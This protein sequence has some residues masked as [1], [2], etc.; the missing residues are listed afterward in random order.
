M[1]ATPK[2]LRS[3][4][5][6][7]GLWTDQSLGQ[8]LD[9]QV[10][11]SAG[12]TLRLWSEQ[13]PWQGTVGEAQDL[14][15]Q[16]AGGLREM[17]V[18]QGDVVA[19][20]LPNCP[21][22]IATFFAVTRLGA[23]LVPIVHFYGPKEV[24]YILGE[25]GAKV[26]ITADAFGWL[27]YRANLK[28]IRPDL[29]HLEEVVFVPMGEP[30]PNLGALTDATPLDELPDVD[31]DAAAL[32]AYTSGTTADPKGVIHTHRS[33]V[34]EATQLGDTQPTNGHLPMLNG[35]PLGHAIGMLGGILLPLYQ[36]NEMHLIDVW[37]PQ[38][39]LDAML[40]A[41][42]YAGSGATYF[43]L[44]LLDHPALTSE[45]LAKMRYI[46]LGGASVPLAVGERATDLGI[47]LI[48]AYGS[49]EHPST[50]GASHDEPLAKRIT[51]DGRPL[52]GVEL[53]IVDEGGNDLPRGEAG[54][55]WSRGPELCAGYTDA[56]LTAENF[57]DDGWY[58]TGDVGILDDDGWLTITDRTRDIIIRGGETIS[59]VE[60]EDLLLR[61]PEVAE[62]AVVAAPD[63]RLGEH[64]CA[65]IR[66]AP[67]QEVP[68]VA[69]VRAHLRDAGL[70]K[71]KWPE[72]IREVDD[73]PRT[74]SGKVKRFELRDRLRETD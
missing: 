33:I 47:S 60:V 61:M 69:A 57:T 49:T 38:R 42:I 31:P 55:I 58:R 65:F 8:Y 62:V 41:N 7:E 52:L 17:G 50:T 24:R 39:I 46:G 34:A 29:P 68:D 51:T 43:L 16:I 53:R 32:I 67:D 14:G 25:S 3:R 64:G 72:E 54:E 6:T 13:R 23:T 26:L 63:E 40:E 12:K 74:P 5:L 10:T 73:F 22:A 30:A 35:A 9:A 36:G 27:D 44:S 21:E 71:Q 19:F 56:A 20:Q 45:H 48:R 15:R 2:A 11:R 37:D 66:V 18:G 59:P 70:A 28:E 4:Y 1:R